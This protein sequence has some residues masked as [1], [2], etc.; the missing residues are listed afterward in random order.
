MQREAGCDA[1]GCVLYVATR[2]QKKKKPRAA[3]IET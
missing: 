1:E 3:A 2:D